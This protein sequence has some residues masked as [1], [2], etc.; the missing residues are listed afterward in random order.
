MWRARVYLEHVKAGRTAQ[1][2]GHAAHRQGARGVDEQIGQACGRPEAEHA[3]LHALGRVGELAR[4]RAEVVTRAGALQH[5]LRARLQLGHARLRRPFGHRHQHVGQIEFELRRVGRLALLLT[6]V[7]VDV[8]LGHAHARV[9][10]AL[11][12]FLQQQLAAQLSAQAVEV[13]HALRSEPAAELGHAE[14]VL[15]GDGLLGLVHLGV[16]DAQTQ[17]GGELQLGLLGDQAFEHLARDLL[18]GRPRAPALRE[19]LLDAADAVAHLV[20]GDRVGVD[21]GDDEVGGAGGPGGAAGRRRGH[22]AAVAQ[23]E[24]GVGHAGR[25]EGQ[26]QGGKGE[27]EAVSH[28]VGTGWAG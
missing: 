21:E 26:D 1:H 4:Q 14:L 5:A 12:H 19:L 15:R 24:L 10:L 8:G 6:Q 18:A 2:A 13:D 22:R 27:T 23:P 9:H 11:P 3:P 16:G 7:V 17:L 20:V 25:G 28:G